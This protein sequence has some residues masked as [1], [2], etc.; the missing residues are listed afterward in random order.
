[1]IRGGQV[2]LE[3]REVNRA[4]RFYVE[5]LG[6]KLVEE[7]GTASAVIDAGEGFLIGLR[8]GAAALGAAESGAD[9]PSISLATKVPVREAIAIYE[10]RGVRFDVNGEGD[11]TVAR[12]RDPDG[13][14]LQLVQGR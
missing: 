13:N 5:T 4:V 3:V 9:A 10:N 12:F 2:T 7:A 14:A 1:M 11:A 8:Q 6:M